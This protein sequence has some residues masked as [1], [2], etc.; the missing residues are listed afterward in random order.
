MIFKPCSP[1]VFFLQSV[2]AFFNF[3]RCDISKQCLSYWR[4]YCGSVTTCHK[5]HLATSVNL[6]LKIKG[7]NTPQTSPTVLSWVEIF[8]AEGSEKNYNCFTKNL[9]LKNEE[10][11]KPLSKARLPFNN[12]RNL[13]QNLAEFSIASCRLLHFAASCCLWLVVTCG[14]LSPFVKFNA[15]NSK[16]KP[17]LQNFDSFKFMRS[18]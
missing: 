3:I 12:Q 10:E 15:P 16:L 9:I 1:L 11:L 4:F 14:K 5:W 13:Q 6:P 8:I 2:E 17:F 18:L 7:D